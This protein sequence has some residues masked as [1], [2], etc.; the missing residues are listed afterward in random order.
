[1]PRKG[2]P[3]FNPGEA[4]YFKDAADIGGTQFRWP[5]MAYAAD[6]K[7]FCLVNEE[8]DAASTGTAVFATFTE[9]NASVQMDGAMAYAQDTDQHYV[10]QNNVWNQIATGSHT[11]LSRGIITEAGTSK[12]LALSDANTFQLFTN[13]AAVTLTIPSNASVAF[14]VG[15]ELDLVQDGAGQVT[16]AA[17]GGVTI[18]SKGALLALTGQYSGAS[19]KKIATDTWVL[20][21]DLA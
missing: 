11:V 4:M 8:G 17:G 19:L 21:G 18:N 7:G 13:A 5:L 15:V 20:V 12:T 3:G 14:A 6:T 16:V 10:R 9:L 2:A 1:M